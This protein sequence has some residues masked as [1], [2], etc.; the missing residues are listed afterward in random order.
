MFEGDLKGSI[1]VILGI[2]YCRCGVEIFP[3]ADTLMAPL[4]LT[5]T[6]DILQ[7]KR[8][9]H[10]Q[11]R[12]LTWIYDGGVGRICPLR[13]VNAALNLGPSSRA[14]CTSSTVTRCVLRVLLVPNIIQQA[15]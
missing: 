11:Y 13:L 3:S 9:F 8:D 4:V 2:Y 14:Q 15:M 7:E 5:V 12:A 10:H 6:S 1:F